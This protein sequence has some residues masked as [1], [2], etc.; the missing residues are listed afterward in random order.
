MHKLSAK[1]F[2]FLRP[3]PRSDVTS[4]KIAEYLLKIK[5]VKIDV[6]NPFQWS[7]GWKSPI[8][9]D[10]RLTLSHPEIRD[11]IK[12]GFVERVKA[13]YP[14]ATG[15]VG[16]ATG[17]IAL[18]VLVAD[19]MGLPFIYVRSKAKGHGMQNLLEGD[20]DS[21]G[22]YVVIEDLVST[23]C[24]SVKAVQAVQATG[25]TV[26]GT[27]SIFSYGFPQAKAAFEETGTQYDSLTNLKTLLEKAQE[28]DYLQADEQATIFDWQQDPANWNGQ[29]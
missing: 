29:E 2:I 1:I 26:L 28:F 25:A 5:A 23:G 15:I 21:N 3:K 19:E 8:Y 24:S 12:H 9:C 17:A 10:N 27:I 18:G 22:K 13:E 6:G 11:F 4:S 7:S 14:E 20:V 16:V